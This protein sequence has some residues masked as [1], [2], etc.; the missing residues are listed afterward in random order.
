MKKAHAG[1]SKMKRKAFTLIELLVVIAIIAILA[2][3]LFP[4]FAKA[5][6]N[7]R[8][9]SCQSNLKQLGLSIMQYTQDYDERMPLHNA[10]G[11]SIDMLL[12]PYVG[13]KE[14]RT[15][16][17]T[18]PGIWQCTSDTAQRFNWGGRMKRSYSVVG[19]WFPDFTAAGWGGRRLQ[20]AFPHSGGASFHIA[21]MEDPAGTFMMAEQD[22]GWNFMHEGNGTWVMIPDGRTGNYGWWNNNRPAQNGIESNTFAQPRHLEGYNYLYVDGHV[23]WLRPNS[24]QAIGPAG[25]PD[26][27]LGAWT[28]IAGD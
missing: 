6:E 2:A 24:A 27:P 12:S 5:R 16:A 23:K 21:E 22:A 3:I 9:A 15:G 25:A 26:W 8:R 28:I 20:R 19:G 17:E 4:V 10:G 14:S 1:Q 13:Q 7:A 11:R 18:D